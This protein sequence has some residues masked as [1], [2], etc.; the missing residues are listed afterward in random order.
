MTITASAQ[1]TN[2]DDSCDIG[3]YP[4]ATLLLPSFEVDAG[5]G[6][7]TIFSIT[8]VGPYPQI[9]KVTLWTDR[10]FPVIS[11]NIFLTGYDFQTINLFDV[12]AR[13]RIGAATGTGTSQPV[14]PNPA[15][16]TR[17]RNNLANP[18][19]AGNVS[20]ECASGRLPGQLA[21]PLAVD[22]RA[23]LT[24]GRSTGASISCDLNGER[25]IGNNHGANW[26]I[27][28]ATIDVVATCTTALPID[29]NYFGE[30]LFDNVLTGDYQHIDAI[31][32]TGNYALGSALVHIRAIPEGGGAG[33]VPTGVTSLPYTFYDR[34]TSRATD[35]KIDRRQ[36]LP[37]TFAARWISGSSAAFATCYKIWREGMLDAEARCDEYFRNGDIPHADIVRFDER[38]NAMIVG[39]ILIGP[40]LPVPRFSATQSVSPMNST[41]FPANTSTDVGGWMYFNLNNG[42]AAAGARYGSRNVSQNW[43]ATSF[44]AEGR[45]GVE[46]DATALGNGCSP[47]TAV[48][49]TKNIGPAPNN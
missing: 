29:R 8:N 6:R 32:T 31:L 25:E 42:G 14:A 37:A 5:T 18:N 49:K 2:N 26:A 47:P 15:I 17:P 39:P 41:S 13:G 21:A 36:P 28:Y 11:F 35:R 19:F 9:A 45:F 33:S 1:T 34:Y 4:A 27:G 16:G 10:A 38:E 3:T 43:V 24:V 7:T 44:F 20:S 12:I 46:Q 22:L 30:I 40:P 23:A 48:N